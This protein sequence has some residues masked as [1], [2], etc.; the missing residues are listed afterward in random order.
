VGVVIA[1]QA[2]VLGRASAAVPALAVSF[3]L[4]LAG[5]AAGAIWSTVQGRWSSVLDVVTSWWWIPL[6]VAGWL[7]VA[8]LGHVASRLGVAPALALVVASQLVAGMIVDAVT[9]GSWPAA[10]AV[11]GVVLLCAGAVLVVQ[12]S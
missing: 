10:R 3:G 11:A 9:G 6:G 7:L 2:A 12:P 5:V 8:A 4:Q 1:V